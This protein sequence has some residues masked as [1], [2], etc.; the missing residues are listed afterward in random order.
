M[1][2]LKLF[3]LVACIALAVPVAA[4]TAP[5]PNGGFE[6]GGAAWTIASNAAVADH[7]ADG[8]AELALAGCGDGTFQFARGV[9]KGVVPASTPLAFDVETGR[10]D[11]WDLR[12]ILADATDPEPYANNLHPLAPDWFD[13]QVLAWSSWSSPLEGAVV[14]DPVDA[15][16]FNIPGWDAM[17]ADARRA[18]LGTMTHMTLVAYGCTTAGATLDGFAWVLG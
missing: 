2:L 5:W 14:L 13:D 6:A 4:T 18:K 3:S 7:D 9:L 17:D 12:M 1:G 16:A 11:A 15:T 8:D 10:V